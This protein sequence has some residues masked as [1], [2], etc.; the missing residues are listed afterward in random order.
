MNKYKNIHFNPKICQESPQKEG[1]PF[2]K[3]LSPDGMALKIS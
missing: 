2:H 3:T 1:L